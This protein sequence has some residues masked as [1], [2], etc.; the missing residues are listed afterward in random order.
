M[1]CT[2][3]AR[4][5]ADTAPIRE[6]IYRTDYWD[7]AHAYNTALPGWLVLVARRHLAAVDELTEA[8]ALELGV[9]IRRVSLALKAVTGCTKTYIMQFAE[10]PQH[11]HVHFHVV[12]RMADQPEDHKGPYIFK[13]LGVDEAERVS[14]AEMDRI[15]REVRRCLAEM[16]TGTPS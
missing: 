6:K 3:T 4:R 2:L 11:S 5:D 1:T 13:Y 10:A 7:V 12:P 9:L 15:A 14:A 16:R 8:E